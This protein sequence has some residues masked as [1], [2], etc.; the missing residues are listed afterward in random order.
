V[1]FGVNWNLEEHMQIIERIG[2]QRQ[3]QSGFDRPV[4]VH[5]IL[6]NRTVDY[7]VLSRLRGKKTVQEVLL[8]AMKRRASGG[9]D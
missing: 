1:F 5:Y 6:A 8:E 3:K 7:M 2:P 9:D 4:F